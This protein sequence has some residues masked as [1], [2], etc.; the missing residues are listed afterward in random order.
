MLEWRMP[1]LLPLLLLILS[2]CAD[3]REPTG[4]FAAA[5][6]AS[7]VV[8]GRSVPDMAASAVTGRDCSVVRLD[9]GKTYCKPPELP[10]ALPPYCTRSLGI[11]DCWANPEALPNHPPELAD[12]PRTL[13]AE[14]ERDRTARWPKSLNLGP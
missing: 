7:V 13:N 6:A 3:W 10:P 12:G 5:N 8:F 14:Q 1:R 9:Q 11:P 4:A 2:G